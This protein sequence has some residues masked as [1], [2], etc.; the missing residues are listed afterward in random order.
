VTVGAAVGRTVALPPP[1]VGKTGDEQIN[2]ASSTKPAHKG[3][4][5]WMHPPPPLPGL[6]YSS[7]DAAVFGGGRGGGPARL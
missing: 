7:H 2:S 4:G 5:G 1:A 3:G 6:R